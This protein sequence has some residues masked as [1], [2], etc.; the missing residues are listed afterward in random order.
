[1]DCEATNVPNGGGVTCPPAFFANWVSVEEAQGHRMVSEFGAPVRARL[2]QHGLKATQDEVRC[3]L[4]GAETKCA[5]LLVEA[6]WPSGRRPAL[7]DGARGQR[8]RVRELPG[9]GWGGDPA[10]LLARV[11]LALRV[12]SVAYFMVLAYAG[13]TLAAWLGA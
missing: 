3:L 7:G 4:A 13:P 2:A 8:G 11:Q 9:T 6:N 1:M 10:A 12:V 5:R